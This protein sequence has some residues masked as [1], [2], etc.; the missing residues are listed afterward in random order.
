MKQWRTYLERV[1][2]YFAEEGQIRAVMRDRGVVEDSW[3]S[4]CDVCQT[5]LVTTE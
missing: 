4:V 1:N 2:G 3:W 5:L